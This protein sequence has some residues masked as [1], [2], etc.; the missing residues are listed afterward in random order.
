MNGIAITEEKKTTAVDTAHQH[1]G[2][3]ELDRIECPCPLREENAIIPGTERTIMINQERHSTSTQKEQREMIE[4]EGIVPV[5][6]EWTRIRPWYPREAIIEITG[7]LEQRSLCLCHQND[8]GHLNPLHRIETAQ[9]PEIR[10]TGDQVLMMRGDEKLMTTRIGDP[11]D[12]YHMAPLNGKK[13]QC[14]TFMIPPLY[15]HLGLV[16][17]NVDQVL[18]IAGIDIRHQYRVHV[19][20]HRRFP[21]VPPCQ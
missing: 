17:H 7:I 20:R 1:P 14:H 16:D 2:T 6:P 15:P 3:R 12:A 5:P 10:D 9:D 18:W 4:T 8:E 19:A 11:N 21:G 13:A